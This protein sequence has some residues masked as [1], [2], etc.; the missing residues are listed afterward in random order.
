MLSNSLSAV[1]NL[2][3]IDALVAVNE[4]LIAS[5]ICAEP[6]KTPLNTPVKLVAVTL[7]LATILPVNSCLSDILS[8]KVLEPV[9]TVTEELKN[10]V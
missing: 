8:P 2:V 3:L 6:D 5:L 10:V 1:V 7:P 9:A 4:P